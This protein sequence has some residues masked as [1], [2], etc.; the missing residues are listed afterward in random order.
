QYRCHP[1]ISAI[2]N[3][4]F[5]DSQLKDGVTSEERSPIV[6]FAA[7][8]CFYNVSRGQEKHGQDGSYYNEEEAKF[9]V[10]MIDRL[11]EAGVEPAQI[12]VITLY[13]S[14]LRTITTHLAA[15]KLTVVCLQI[16][17]VDAFQGGEKDVVLLSCVR[18][19]RVGFIDCDRRTNVALTRAKRHLLIIGSL[20][21][22]SSNAVWGN[23]IQHCRGKS[24]RNSNTYSE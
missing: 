21:M 8:L 19:K 18:T 1:V 24:T 3:K 4:L 5:Y 10:F 16:S 12:G 9:V 22:L 2:A 17:T 23:V 6:D 14:Q 13:K 7:T 15:S 11:L 20:R